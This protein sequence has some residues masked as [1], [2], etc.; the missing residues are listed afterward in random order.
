MQDFDCS[1]RDWSAEPSTWISRYLGSDK[2]LQFGTICWYLWKSRNE[3]V[4]SASTDSAVTIAAR[5]LSWI[6]VIENALTKSTLGFIGEQDKQVSDIAWEPGPNG[7]WVLNTDGSVNS[8]GGKATAGK[9][10]RDSAGRCLFAFTMNLGSC[11]ITRAEIR[12]AI[13]G[14]Q[15]AWEAG[16]KKVILRMDSQAAISILTDEDSTE[17]QHGLEVLI[18]REMCSRN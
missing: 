12:G 6:R 18:F 4:F 2:K 10:L 5:A 13:R 8:I 14:L 9:L 15:L 16:F 1:E 3:R 11:S 7:W 17:H